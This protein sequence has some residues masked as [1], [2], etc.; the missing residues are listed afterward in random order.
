MK[1]SL[2]RNVRSSMCSRLVFNSGSTSFKPVNNV[3]FLKTLK[4][5][6]I[7][8]FRFLSIGFPRLTEE[9]KKPEIT[10]AGQLM[11]EKMEREKKEDKKENSEENS[12]VKSKPMGKWEKIGYSVFGISFVSLLIS[13]A[14][15]FCKDFIIFNSC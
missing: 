1:G 9:S 4:T 11:R 12:G 10:L 7:L 8:S 5:P 2:L 15:I 13:N 14:V 6:P 3:L